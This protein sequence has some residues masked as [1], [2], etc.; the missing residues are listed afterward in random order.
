MRVRGEYS[1]QQPEKLR[2]KKRSMAH[3]WNRKEPHEAEAAG[4]QGRGTGKEL[5]G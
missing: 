2:K 5:E 1:S 3:M 4:T